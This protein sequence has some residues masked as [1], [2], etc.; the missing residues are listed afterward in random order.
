MVTNQAKWHKTVTTT[1]CWKGHRRG[2]SASRRLQSSHMSSE[3]SCFFCGQAAGNDGLHEVTTF[4]VDQRVRDC[5]ELA[6]T[7]PSAY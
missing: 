4:Q 3:V 1:K 2:N 7:I 5:A 6:S